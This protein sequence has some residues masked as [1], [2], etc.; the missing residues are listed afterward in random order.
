MME[1]YIRIKDGQPFEHPILGDNFREAF[2]QIDPENLPPEFARF[3]R[4]A[5]PDVGVYEVY[6][7]V[8]YEW[9]NG[10]VK[11]FHH[12][13]QL[14]EQEK[15]DKQNAVKDAW[16][17]FPNWSSWSFDEATCSFKPPIPY[18]QDGKPYWWDEATLSW[19]EIQP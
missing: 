9:D 12:V 1:L 3:D 4:I 19:V 17:A 15:T 2:P 18:P 11:D 6:Q 13:R 10:R 16:A 5:P 14:T 8:T 7:G